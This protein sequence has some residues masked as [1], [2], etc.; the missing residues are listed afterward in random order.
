MCPLDAFRILFCS[1]RRKLHVRFTL[2]WLCIDQTLYTS[3]KQFPKSDARTLDRRQC[4]LRAHFAR[5]Q[6]TG[7]AVYQ[8]A[9]Y[10]SQTTAFAQCSISVAAGA[11]RRARTWA[12]PTRARGP[13]R[14]GCRLLR[15]TYRC[16]ES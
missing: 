3:R 8:Q 2:P 12:H 13:A 4:P 1:A 11:I 6:Y 14:R 9:K 10:V 16:N 15:S 7:F 5:A